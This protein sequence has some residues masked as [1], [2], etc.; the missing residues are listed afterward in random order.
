LSMSDERIRLRL[1]PRQDSE[2]GT[3]VLTVD[4]ADYDIV[5]ADV[6]DPL[7]NVTRLRFSNLERA[8][9]LQDARFRFE[10]PPGVDV[11][12]SPD[13]GEGGP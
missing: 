9:G 10:V 5:G 4:R 2:I 1:E 6:T 13:L 7:G 8:V 11:V 3:L 12:E